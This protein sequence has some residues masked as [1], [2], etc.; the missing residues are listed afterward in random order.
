MKPSFWK[1]TWFRRL[2]QAL[3]VILSVLLLAVAAINWEGRSVR[4]RTVAK[5]QAEGHPLVMKPLLPPLP[6]D[7]QNFAMIPLFVQVKEEKRRLGNRQNEGEMW[8]KLNRMNFLGMTGGLL[9]LRDREPDFK[10]WADALKC[11]PTPAAIADRYDELNAVPLAALREGMSRPYAQLSTMQ[12]FM[13]DEEFINFGTPLSYLLTRAA[14]G[15]VC[16]AHAN[17]AAGR[18]EVAKESLR[19]GCRIAETVGSDGTFIARLYQC[20]VLNQLYP[21]LARSLRAGNWSAA[22]L[23]AL[24]AGFDRMDLRE[25][26]LHASEIENAWMVLAFDYIRENRAKA[27]TL[28]VLGK[29]RQLLV[30]LVPSGLIDRQLAEALATRCEFSR[31]LEKAP[32]MSDWGRT[33][34][35]FQAR[36]KVDDSRG[37]WLP[38]MGGINAPVMKSAISATVR[39]KEAKLACELERFR[40]LNGRYP[41]DLQEIGGTVILDPLDGEP[42]RYSVQDGGY[43]LYSLG[44]NGKDDDGRE[45]PPRGG[46]VIRTEDYDLPW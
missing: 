1:R 31:A 21:A 22:E 17:L 45:L 13:K 14:D 18:P 10:G 32:R 30:R 11:E 28:T 29:T 33:C 9:Y 8:D 4:N 2:C 25:G 5:L 15:L 44:P 23:D 26:F 20:R 36:E 16:R 6:P 37:R 46:K 35:E 41:K 27:S 40:L 24:E 12:E 39:L 38:G 7:D 43:R 19:M 34:D 3:V 42:F